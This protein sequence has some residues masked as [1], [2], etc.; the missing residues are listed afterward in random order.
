MY[1][2]SAATTHYLANIINEDF[3]CPKRH[4]TP[5]VADLTDSVRSDFAPAVSPEVAYNKRFSATLG[6]WRV[7][8]KQ[9]KFLQES[10]TV[11]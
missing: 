5:L 2:A 4:F 6:T 10:K 8:D 7:A 11:R 1:A 9:G 3:L